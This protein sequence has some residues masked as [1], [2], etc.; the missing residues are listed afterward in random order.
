MEP[1]CYFLGDIGCL[2]DNLK[3]MVINIQMRF[4]C[5]ERL[6]LLGDNFYN[7]GVQTTYDDLWEIYKQIFEPIK[8][9]NIYSVL[10]NHDYE[11]NPYA[12]IMSPYM[13]N[14]DFY[15]KYRFSNKTEIFLIDT[16]PLHENHCGITIRDMI[17]V[18][19]QYYKDLEKKQ[20]KWLNKSLHES[21]AQNKIVVGHYPLLSNGVYNKYLQPMY[22]KLMPI[23]EKYNVRAYIC[24]HEH[25]IQYIEKLYNNY[26]FNQF[27]VGSSSEYRPDES[28]IDQDGSLYDATDNFYLKMSESGNRLIF[29]YINKDGTLKYC[30]II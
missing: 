16:V 14:K 22:N 29:D 21:N 10:G 30:Y 25:N 27:I 17:R 8:F 7:N 20:L 26:H 5:G 1:G 13:M 23:F 28:K 19:N 24:G 2:N 18:H 6:F 12:Q 9:Q 11:G 15:Y 3:Q 4:R